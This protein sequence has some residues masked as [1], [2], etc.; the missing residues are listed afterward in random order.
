MNRK[1]SRAPW[2]FLTVA[3]LFV[4]ATGA[5]AQS[6]GSADPHTVW[7]YADNPA[8]WSLFPDAIAF[9][10]RAEA[11]VSDLASFAGGTLPATVDLAYG[12]PGLVYRYRDDGSSSTHALTSAFSFGRSFGLGLR[13]RWDGTTTSAW[14]V[15]DLGVMLRPFGYASV[16]ASVDD[17]LDLSGDGYEAALG[18]AVRPLAFNP[19]LGS[20]LT[21]SADARLGP[22]GFAMA[23][24]GARFVLADW[25]SLSG[26]YS[27]DDAS[28]GLGFAV[29]LSGAETSV[30]GRLN[31]MHQ[32]GD[33]SLGQSVRLGRAAKS[34]ERVFG[35]SVL[36]I[37]EPGLFQPNPPRVDMDPGFGDEVALWFDLAVAAIDRAAS[38][39]SIRALAMFE[40]PLFDTDAR[41]QEFCRALGR[42][43]VAGKPVYVFAQ[44]MGR[45]SYVYAAAGAELV[46]LDPNGG[47]PIVDV[48]S[49]HLYFKDLLARLGVRTYSLQSH[50]TKTAN[51]AM[52][53]PSM[54][55]PERAMIERYVGGLASQAWASLDEARGDRVVGGGRA[56]IGAGPY[57]DPRKAVEA[58]LADELLY[59]DEFEERLTEL[60]AGAGRVDLRSYARERGLEWGPP[61]G[62]KVAVVYLSGSI[63]EGEGVAGSSIGES[64]AEL[65]AAL[66]DDPTVAGVIMRV[67]SGGGSALTSDHI[68]RQVKKLKDS[69]KPVVV[70][71]AGYAASGGYYISAYADRIIAEA[72]TLTGSIGVTGFDIN[73]TG[74]LELLGVGSGV[75]SAGPSGEFGNPF[76]PRREADGQAERGMIMYIYERFVN[77]VA[78][79]RG[80]DRAR[81]DE[82][83]KGQIWLG[84][85]AVENGLVD[86]LGG[87]VDAKAA[88]EELLG[89]AG[90]FEAYLPGTLEPG[91]ILS[92]LGLAKAG[93]ASS[94]MLASTRAFVNEL[95]ELGEGALYL[96]PEYLYRER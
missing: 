5:F 9:G 52:T 29:S 72:G 37:D 94:S 71:M 2:R 65:L 6:G 24:A 62:R 96:A 23:G 10:V 75:V 57:L 88:M 20:A 34:A 77:V 7:D 45:L 40:P 95:A 66:R 46:A 53:E 59:R 36:V 28:F 13:F 70:S 43:R 82:L 92:L 60:T 42:F 55:G 49:T 11:A 4:V 48:S 73:L 79:G 93:G 3:A 89:A 68:A 64:A 18:L 19:R 25:L 81:V 17:V 32:G 51:N 83:G 87:L 8:A 38:D 33:V 30:G 50:D 54:T 44:S 67:D 80:M 76:L 47:L 78:E 14:G 39:A 16:S 84:S 63:I 56:A 21:L 12:L 22:D 74:T 61:P 91:S 1:H 85:E 69:G 31:G 86:A 35:S 26:S 15:Q 27:F 90:R 41:A 58:G